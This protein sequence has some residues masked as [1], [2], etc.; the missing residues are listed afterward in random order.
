VRRD[1]VEGPVL[2]RSSL[3]LIGTLGALATLSHGPVSGVSQ[4]DAPDAIPFARKE[5]Q[6][7]Q[8]VRVSMVSECGERRESVSQGG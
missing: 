8:G 7:P 5:T 6:K 3:N 4:Y 2:S 1:L